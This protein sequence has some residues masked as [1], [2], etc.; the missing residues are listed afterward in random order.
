[1]QS[2]WQIINKKFAF[3]GLKS[4]ESGIFFI[5]IAH[6]DLDAIF[7]SEMFD[8]YVDFIKLTVEKE[9]PSIQVFPTLT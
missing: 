9:Y 5:V 8:L 4:S 1:M 3:F 7:P 6:F 2:I